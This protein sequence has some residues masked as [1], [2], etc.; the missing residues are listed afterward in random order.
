MAAMNQQQI[1]KT[2]SM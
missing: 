2:L 1:I